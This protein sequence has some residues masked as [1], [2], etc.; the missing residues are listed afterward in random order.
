MIIDR[1]KLETKWDISEVEI[2]KQLFHDILNSRETVHFE[3]IWDEHISIYF[4]NEDFKG[5]VWLN[6]ISYLNYVSQMKTRILILLLLSIYHIYQWPTVFESLYIIRVWFFE[7]L[8]PWKVL[9]CKLYWRIIV[10]H[11]SK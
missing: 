11:Y 7:L 2:L 8:I 4:M 6:A 1:C 9:Y 5:N 10:Y 3:V